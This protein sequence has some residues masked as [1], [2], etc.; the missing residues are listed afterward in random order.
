MT[1]TDRAHLASRLLP[2]MT[3]G[4]GA[5]GSLTA[6]PAPLTSTSSSPAERAAQR[7]GLHGQNAIVTGGAG[8]LGSTAARALL[9][10]GLSGLMVF[11]RMDAA[12]AELRLA[13]LKAEFPRA[14]IGFVR[15]DIA[16]EGLVAEAVGVAERRFQENQGGIDILL[17]FA[18]MVGCGDELDSTAKDWERMLGVNL[19]GGA[20]VAR[21]VARAMIARGKGGSMVFVASISGH[22]VNFPQP[23]V[24]YNVSK[25]GVMTMVRS[26]A[27]EWAVHGIRINSISPGYMDTV[28]N[29]GAGLDDGR[30]MWASRCPMGRMGQPDEL[31]G[32]VVLLASRAG[33]YITG[34]DLLIDGGQTLLM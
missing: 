10:H 13:A 26:M 27:A 25:A 17:N 11:D 29:E 24:A 5:P 18:G 7:F 8:D 23:Q 2:Q 32:A 1:R 31:A 15:V 6:P 19:V 9:E 20:S 30:K 12:E 16:D 3:L 14:D 21:S 28:L 22:Q 4:S 33:S 34:T